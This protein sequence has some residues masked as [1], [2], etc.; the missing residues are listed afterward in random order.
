MP[1]SSF[2]TRFSSVAGF[3]AAWMLTN[4]GSIPT[5]AAAELK[6]VDYVNPY[7]GNISH[8]LVP[9]FPTVHLPNS[10]M[11][12]NPNR[13]NFTTVYLKGFPLIVTA[14]HESVAFNLKTFDGGPDVTQPVD[15]SSY[16]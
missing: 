15:Q 13:E 16:D 12:I 4:F 7:M 11:R 8:L 5:R 3:M 2:F 1:P 9:A 14:R 10:M 6:P